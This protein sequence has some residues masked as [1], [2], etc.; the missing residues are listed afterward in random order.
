MTEESWYEVVQGGSLEQGDILTGCSIIRPLVPESLASIPDAPGE[1]VE[2]EIELVSEVADV[3]ILSQTCDLD[4]SKV[5]Q[6][7]VAKV[8]SYVDLVEQETAR[9][10]TAVRSKNFR[11]ACVDGNA[12]AQFLL[13]YREGDPSI[14]WSLVEFHHLHLLPKSYLQAH[15]QTF[16]G[17]LRLM[18]P[19]KEHLGQS[20]ARYF[21]R[22]ALP[23][24]A[25]EF[26]GFDPKS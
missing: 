4:N 10:N 26:Q 9:G 25:H 16:S 7:L 2:Y 20:L 24:G 14:P 5:D 21:M 8:I 23:K 15:A 19:Y 11:K 3:V 13:H 17:R 12:P 22:V 18:S 6:V 1:S